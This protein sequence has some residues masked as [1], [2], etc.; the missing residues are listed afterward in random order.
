[1][2]LAFKVERKLTHPEEII[3]NFK[4]VPDIIIANG[5]AISLHANSLGYR[6]HGKKMQTIPIEKKKYKLLSF[7]FLFHK[8]MKYDIKCDDY[9]VIYKLTSEDL[10]A[11][12]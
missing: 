9:C 6:I 11:A 2:E 5:G 10:R 8:E 12:I 3:I 4:K 7:N 1:L